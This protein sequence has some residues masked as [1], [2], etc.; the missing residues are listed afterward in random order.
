VSDLR[1]RIY[2]HRIFVC[3]ACGRPEPIS[4]LL[5]GAK[6]CSSCSHITRVTVKVRPE[7]SVLGAA[8]GN[9]GDASDRITKRRERYNNG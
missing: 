6:R 9:R 3:P 2:S 4:K 8:E 1:Q 7:E 5:R